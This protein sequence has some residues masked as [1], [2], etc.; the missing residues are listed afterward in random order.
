MYFVSACSEYGLSMRPPAF[1]FAPATTCVVGSAFA[2]VLAGC[3]PEAAGFA[4]GTGTAAACPFCFGAGV[5]TAAGV[6]ADAGVAGAFGT[7]AGGFGG[8]AAGSGAVSRLC[9]IAGPIVSASASALTP[10]T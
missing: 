6:V 9:A 3:A 5:V 4:L 8:V 7:A 2:F 10:A 1:A